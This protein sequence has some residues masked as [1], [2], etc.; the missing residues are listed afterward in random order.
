MASY[1]DLEAKVINTGICTVCGACI[2]ACP[3]SHVKFIEGKPTRSKRAMDC[4][5]CSTCYEAC[6]MLRHDLIRNIEGNILGWGKKDSVG[7]YK[8]IV[9]AR[10]REQ[11]I[12]KA[13]Q[14][15]GIVTALLIY[16]LGKSII[17]GALAV[18]S[19]SWMPVAS[20]AKTRDD[21]ILAAGTKYGVVPVLK[22]LRSAVID[23]GLSKICVVGSPCHI[24]SVRYLKHKGLPLASSVK[25]TVSL[26]CRENYDYQCMMEK[27]NEKGLNVDQIDKLNVAEEFSVYAGGKRLSFPITE[28]KSCVPKHCLVCEDFAGE[29]ADVSIG[30]DGSPEGWS[31]VIIRTEEGEAVFSGLETE[32][33]VETKVGGDL[34]YIK[35]IAQRKKEKGKQTKDIFKLKEG[36]LGGKEIAAKLGITEDRVSHRLEGL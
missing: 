10:T 22:E 26:F 30:S 11:D 2:L 25:L 23:H 4:V 7:I 29:L 24:Q 12:K 13:C 6:Y 5:G 31:T 28:V 14:D 35:E 36:G 34:V 15:G 18:G 3:T 21:V 32:G 19:D 27:A 17:D 16:A 20:I 8:R 33:L 9:V 1:E